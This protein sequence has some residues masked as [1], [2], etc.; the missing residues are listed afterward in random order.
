MK[1]HFDKD[2]TLDK[3]YRILCSNC[4]TDTNHKVLSSIYETGSEPM[5]HYNTFLS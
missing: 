5:D 1:V 4:K 3:K 2:Q